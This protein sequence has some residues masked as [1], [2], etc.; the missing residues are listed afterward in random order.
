M[1]AEVSAVMPASA[2]L[3]IENSLASPVRPVAMTGSS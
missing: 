1:S 3:I 2:P